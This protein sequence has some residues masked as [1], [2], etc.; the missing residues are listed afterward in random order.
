MLF[1]HVSLGLLTAAHVNAAADLLTDIT[2]ISRSWGQ[3]SVYADNDEDHFGV[4][5]VGLPEGCQVVSYLSLGT[6]FKID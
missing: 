1:T 6:S 4:G 2:K 3:V 5:Y